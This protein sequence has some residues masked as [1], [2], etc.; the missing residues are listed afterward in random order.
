LT[1]LE[2]N[3]FNLCAKAAIVVNEFCIRQDEMF[4]YFVNICSTDMS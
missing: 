3:F 4:C 1:K 2:A